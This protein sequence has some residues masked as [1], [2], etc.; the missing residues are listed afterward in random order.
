ME[1]IQRAQK[2]AGS[3]IWLST[4]SRPDICYA[5][6]R[7]SSM[8]SKAP[9]GALLEGIRALRSLQGTKDVGL[10]F[11]A[12]DDHEDVIAYTDANFSVKRSQTGSFVKLGTNV[13]TLRSMKQPTVSSSS[14]GSEVQ[15]LTSTE[16]FADFIKTLRE[17]VRQASQEILMP[18]A[19]RP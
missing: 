15:A 17:F 10:H 4:R 12:C 3:L 16:K 2:S 6:S 13:F 7:T 1:L 5:Q 14:A 18:A 9:Q 11:T 8:S 19:G